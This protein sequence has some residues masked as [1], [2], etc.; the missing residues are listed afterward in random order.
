MNLKIRTRLLG[1]TLL[2]VPAAL[3]AQLSIDWHTIDGG[4]GT[5]S[6]GVYSVVGT[7]GQPDAG[8]P[9]TNGQFS[10]TGGFWAFPTAVQTAGAPT[11]II[12]RAGPGLA[13]ISWT[14]SSPGF[15]LQETFSLSP[16]NW[17][18]SPS[19]ATNPI[20]VPSSLLTKF[21]RL[22]KP[23]PPQDLGM[24]ERSKTDSN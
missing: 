6:G 7:I 4:G 14:P 17:V 1:A 9:M 10:V 23:Q 21:Y 20:A 13:M 15:V 16:T 11:L 5:S 12:A 22:F 24:A 8:G 3:F 19:G 2:L 18:T